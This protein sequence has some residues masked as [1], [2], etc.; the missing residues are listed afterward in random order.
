MLYS[1][2][3]GLALSIL[4]FVLVQCLPVRMNL[5]TLVCG[6]II[7]AFFIVFL[8]VY[9]SGFTVERWVVAIMFGLLFGAI[10]Y[11]VISMRSCF[12]MHGIYLK[13]STKIVSSY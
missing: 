13:N 8:L 2:L 6:L 11:G 9:A 10:L 4:F 1:V 12:A 5:M 7:V 3:I